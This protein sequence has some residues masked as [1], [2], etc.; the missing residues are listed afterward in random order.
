MTLTALLL[1]L[2]LAAA[3]SSADSV[4][5]VVLNHGRPA[6]EMTVVHRG[7]S[8][9]VHYHHVDRNRGP[10]SETHYRIVRGEVLG[11]ATWQLPLYGPQ[12]NP[13]GR[14]LDWFEAAGDSV[15]CRAG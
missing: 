3:P 8:V 10:R 1:A 11:G 6:G 14:P 13:L 12:P 5:Y 2:P 4:R 15:H 7:D 9:V